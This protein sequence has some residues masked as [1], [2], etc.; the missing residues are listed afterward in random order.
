MREC[1]TC[2]KQYPDDLRFC[3]EDGATLVADPENAQLAPSWKAVPE[4]GSRR[5]TYVI[6]ILLFVV[7]GGFLI[8]A[9][10]VGYFVYRMQNEKAI[11][12]EPS[13]TPKTTPSTT[14]S[15]RP[16]NTPANVSRGEDPIRVDPST[17]TTRKPLPKQIS[18]GV[19]N[20]KATSLPKPV[21]P[22]AARA[23]RA[24]GSVSVQVL[25]NEQGYVEKAS[26]V[27]GHP[28]LRASAEQAARIARFEP[29]K[30][31]GQAVKVS[32]VLMYGFTPD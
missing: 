23:V 1:P 21:Y 18:G 8:A 6:A 5:W 22:P 26:A 14:A 28:L 25:V 16:T 30:L 32:G 15:P 24:T 10:A 19:L 20:G 11:F 3:L 17:E 7:G 27:S 29:T 13:P 4:Q 31:S 2:K 9:G 12:V